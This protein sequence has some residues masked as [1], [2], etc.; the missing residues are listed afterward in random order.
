MQLFEEASANHEKDFEDFRASSLPASRDL[1][2]RFSK[3]AMTH[4]SWP[5]MRRRQ[6]FQ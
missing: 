5:L 6:A 4:C 2:G 1:H 3:L